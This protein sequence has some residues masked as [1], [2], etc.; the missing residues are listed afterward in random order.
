LDGVAKELISRSR[1]ARLGTVDEY[2][3]PYV[4]PVVFVFDGACF[5]IPLDSKRKTVRSRDLRRVKNIEKNAKVSLLVDE[6]SESW[7]ELWFIMIMGVAGILE[8]KDHIVL[9]KEIH[10]MLIAKYPQ[11]ESLGIGESCI[12]IKPIKVISWK[13]AEASIEHL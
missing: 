11:Y 4:I 10:R 7:K 1:V 8:K 2:N 6:Y 12:K 13:N 3:Q 9:I 5:F